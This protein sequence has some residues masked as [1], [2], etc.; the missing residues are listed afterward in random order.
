M[1]QTKSMAELRCA[2]DEGFNFNSPLIYYNLTLALF[3]LFSLMDKPKG[4]KP[5]AII[6]AFFFYCRTI[7]LVRAIF[8]SSEFLCYRYPVISAEKIVTQ[9]RIIKT[10]PA[11][12][13]LL[14]LMNNYDVIFWQKSQQL[15][16]CQ[17]QNLLSNDSS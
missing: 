14:Y 2:R 17:V 6:Y 15:L 3:K 9:F 7:N 1:R 16:T 8:F 12:I 11:L 13:G 4:E 5:H 10:I